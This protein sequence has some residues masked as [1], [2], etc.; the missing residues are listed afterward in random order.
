MTPQFPV[1]RRRQSGHEILEFGLVAMLFIPLLMGTFVVGMNT[2]R[3]I[4]ANHIAR[5]LAD[6][7]IHG[8]DFSRHGAQVITQR[9]STGLQLQFPTFS[10]NQAD[11]LG[12]TGRGIVYISRVVWVGP[13]TDPQCQ[14][15]L[16]STCTNANQFVFTQRVRFG[17]TN[18]QSERPSSIGHPTASRNSFGTVQDPVTNAGARIPAP[19][20]T[21]MQ[22]LWQTT[23]NGRQP[24][25]DGQGIYIVEVYFQSPDLNLG[26]FPGRGVYAIWNF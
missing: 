14:A 2:V 13:T 18:L 6:M 9:L 21:E 26:S 25:V 20:Q 23:A 1:R 12:T 22:S 10:G 24:L 17:N 3:S 16:P 8:V 7:Y 15:V 11:N 5:D 19:Y 4:Q